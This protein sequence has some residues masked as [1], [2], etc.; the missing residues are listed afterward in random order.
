M[1]LPRLLRKE[2]AHKL[3][4]FDLARFDLARRLPTG[5]GEQA[6]GEFTGEPGPQQ[7][8]ARRAPLG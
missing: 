3:P 4:A 1:G 8:I 2:V 5:G 7:A 6:R